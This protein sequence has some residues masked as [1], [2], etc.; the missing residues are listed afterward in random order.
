MFNILTLKESMKTKGAEVLECNAK[1]VVQ[2]G[3]E[4]KPSQPKQSKAEKPQW[5]VITIKTLDDGRYGVK[6]LPRVLPSILKYSNGINACEEV[7]EIRFFMSNDIFFNQFPNSKALN[8]HIIE[9]DEVM[10]HLNM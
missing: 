2:L 8:F 1:E 3:K 7:T 5:H 9:K 10:T 4:Q 6:V